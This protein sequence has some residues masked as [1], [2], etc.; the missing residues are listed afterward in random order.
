[1][2]KGLPSA[3]PLTDMRAPPPIRCFQGAGRTFQWKQSPGL[4]GHAGESCPAGSGELPRVFGYC[5]TDFHAIGQL[6]P[7]SARLG[8]PRL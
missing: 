2:N 1:M 4:S 3:L 5:S 7:A 8:I 6:P